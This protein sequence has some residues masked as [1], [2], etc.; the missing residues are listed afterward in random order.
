[1]GRSTST[2][3]EWSTFGRDLLVSTGIVPRGA[4]GAHLCDTIRE[5]ARTGSLRPGVRLPATRVLAGD[6]GVSR[7]LIC[8]VYDQLK[9][10]GYLTSRPGSG[11]VVADAVNHSAA[12]KVS[13]PVPQ[14][15]PTQS[16]GL[17]DPR[18]FPR[19]EWLKAYRTVLQRL[20]DAEL[21]YPDPQGYLPL[22]QELADYLGRVRGLR[23]RAENI[24]IVNGYA[25]GLAI[26]AMVL[27]Q[28]DIDQVAVEE[29]G[30]SGTRTQLND[31]A[32][33]TPPVR[34]DDQ[35]LDVTSLHNCGASA[36]LLTPAHHYPTGVVLAPAR[37]HQLLDWVAQQ[38]G[39]Y[40]IEDDY[41]AEYRYDAAPVGS[42]QP[43]NPSHVITGSSVSKTLSP[44]LRLGW[45]VL[46]QDLVTLSTAVKATFDLGNSLLDQAT[47]AELLST[48]DF[49]R[50]LRRSRRHYRIRRQHVVD[51]LTTH[52]GD[53]E[54]SG[55]DAGLN[56]CIRLPEHVDDRVLAEHL[57][58]TGTR[59]EAL[60]HYHQLP[61]P[62]R[63]LIL[64]I[65]TSTTD[66]L[67]ATV[68]AIRRAM[69]GPLTP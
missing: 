16:P 63:G 21:H 26:L 11:T 40:I 37:R 33:A 2:P 28:L 55:L 53:V 64:D 31:W 32:I 58:S 34:V 48:G 9:A 14:D 30:S 27:R 42:L 66:D 61:S 50:H 19:R 39:R 22:R 7:G 6:L 5:A 67:E 62:S 69:A 43:F 68:A 12:Q 36:V 46:P 56:I 41:D 3:L 54:M 57:T 24:L 49:D 10:E 29:P 38:A 59:C 18:L 60:S 52:L 35:G 65:T 45:L 23:T 1:M 25:Q 44:A 15:R 4:W 51:Y 8:G 13:S 47:F 20:P 17:P